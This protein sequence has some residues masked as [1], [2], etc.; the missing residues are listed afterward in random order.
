MAR[1]RILDPG[2]WQSQDFG[3]LTTLAKL[4]FIG[5]FSQADDEGRGRANPQYIK[6]TLFPYDEDL[7]RKDIESAFSEIAKNMSIVFY[8]S[9]G[10]EYYALTHWEVWQKVDKPQ[11][12]KLPEPQGN[13]RNFT[14]Q[15]T[16]GTA[17][18]ETKGKK[19]A[20]FIPPTLEEVRAYCREQK[21]QVDPERFINH[22]TSNGWKVGKTLMVDWKAAVRTWEKNSKEFNTNG[23]VKRDN[24]EFDPAGMQRFHNALEECG[25]E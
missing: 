23:A 20:K 8:E 2:I 13:S 15:E 21:N 5:L 14:E 24:S 3:N 17:P 7:K 18:K 4:V 6:N 9:D 10:G 16:T 1:K 11:K 12:S 22:Y 25:E 19:T